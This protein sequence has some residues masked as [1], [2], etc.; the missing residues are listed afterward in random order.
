VEE[1]TTELRESRDHLRELTQHVFVAQEEERR[2]ISREL[3]DEAGQALIGLR[4]SLDSIYKELP[5]NL[6]KL[7]QRMAK[8][9]AL[10]DQTVNRIR[11][12][13][14]NLRSPALDLLGV[15]LGIKELCREFSDQTGI[16]V[17]YSGVDLEILQ[18]EINISLYRFVQ[19][20]LTNVAK[21]AN[22]S[23]VRVNLEYQD[24]TIKASVYDDGQ[25]ISVEKANSGIGILGIK[26]RFD[27][28]GGRVEVKPVM[29]NGTQI[30]VCLPWNS[31]AKLVGKIT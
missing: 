23:K 9:L 18:D 7:R 11:T 13:A 5:T 19:E 6:R 15:N 12:L 27:N 14:Y 4:F 29:P 17:E 26:E 25:G 20:S 22:A 10:I 24:E 3:H 1:R 8:S 30:Q 28:L 31:A 21:H 2:R 16:E